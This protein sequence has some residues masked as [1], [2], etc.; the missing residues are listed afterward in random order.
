M[1]PSSTLVR[2]YWKGG[3]SVDVPFSLQNSSGFVGIQFD[4]RFDP[5]VFEDVDTS[6]CLDAFSR[7]GLLAACRRQAWPNE[8]V[9]RFIVV[10]L[11]NQPVPSGALGELTLRAASDAPSGM[12]VVTGL[13]CT[14]LAVDAGQNQIGLTADDF[15][16]GQIRIRGADPDVGVADGTPLLDLSGTEAPSEGPLFRRYFEIDDLIPALTSGSLELELLLP[17]GR[18]VLA[19]RSTYAPRSG[20]VERLDCRGNPVPDNDPE[21]SLSLR[22]YGEVDQNGWMGVTVEKDVVRG[23]LVTQEHSYQIWGTA[24]AGYVLAEIDPD[25]LP[26]AHGVDLFRGDAKSHGINAADEVSPLQTDSALRKSGV[27]I[28]LDLLIMCTAQA[29]IDAGG[30]AG[31]DALIQQS[32]DNTDQALINSGFSNLSVKEAHRELLVG[33]VPSGSTGQNAISDRDLLR[34]NAQIIA[35]RNA[36]FADVTMVLLRDFFDGQGTAQ[37]GACGI[38]YLQ[39]PTCGGVGDVAQCGVGVDFENY[40]LSWVSVQCAALAGRNSFPHELG[41]LMGAEHQP[42]PVSQD[43]MDASFVWSYAHLRTTGTQ[44]GTLM[45]VPNPTELP[46]PLNFS[47][48]HVF[49]GSQP[50]GIANQRDNVRTFEILTPVMELFRVPP[51]ELLFADSFES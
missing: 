24:D 30:A 6:R 4:L 29:E 50:S 22:W 39:S 43:P 15:H 32:I 44:F 35:A 8:D 27:P 5:S 9:I 45:W 12:S 26:P 46:Q 16:P 2:A 38:A 3:A 47:N 31:L 25:R 13:E 41:H 37:L 49:I 51:P 33:F 11:D 28:E 7:S 14:G 34:Q 1:I 20:F 10:S 40:A 42:G 19:Q 17:D 48:P 21:T 36:S 23:T 18:R